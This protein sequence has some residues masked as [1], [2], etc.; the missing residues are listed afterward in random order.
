MIMS[1]TDDDLIARLKQQ[2]K[3]K[4]DIEIRYQMNKAYQEKLVDIKKEE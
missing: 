3:D 4:A 2:E 1:R